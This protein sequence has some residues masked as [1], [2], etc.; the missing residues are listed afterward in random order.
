MTERVFVNHE[1]RE[2]IAGALIKAAEL[3]TSHEGESFDRIILA[4]GIQPIAEAAGLDRVVFLRR[5]EMDGDERVGQIYCWDKLEGALT[6]PEQEPHLLPETQP[7]AHWIGV[8]EKNNCV[9]LRDEDSTTE[10]ER[11]F[12]R[13]FGVK[14][15]MLIPIFS[16]GEFWGAVGFSGR[17]SGLDFDEDCMDLLHSAAHLC[18][19]TVMRAETEEHTQ[20]QSRQLNIRLEQQ[21]LV[22]EIT[23]ILI[24][25]GDTELH[26]EKV[27]AKLGQYYKASQVFIFSID[28][29]QDGTYPTYYWSE[30]NT[31]LRHANVN[32][33][34]WI[35][36]SFPETLPVTFTLP[37]ISCAD[38]AA[39]RH[40]PLYPL[41]EI[42]VNAFMC[43]PLYLEGRLW[44]IMSVEQCNA[45]RHWTENEKLFV[46]MAASTISGII[47][48]NTYT[49][50][51][52]AAL[53]KATE[54][55]RAKSDFL[56]NMSHEMRTPLN[57]IIGM[58]TIGRKAPDIERKNYSL[59]MIEDASAQLLGV[60][61]DVLDM[62]KIAENKLELSYIEFNLEKLLKKTTAI[63]SIRMEE[64]KLSFSMHIDKDIPQ[65]MIGD[66]QRLTQVITNLLGNAVKFTPVNGSIRLET[67]FAGEKGGF[68]TIL[69]SVSDTGIGISEE[70]QKHL[71]ESFQQA[72]SST[73]RRYGGTGLGLAISKSIVEMMKGEI[74]LDS[75]LGKGSVFTFTVRMKRGTAKKQKDL[76]AET[77]QRTEES[78]RGI[79]DLFDGCC[80]LL[81][82]DVE[83]NRDIVLTLLEPTRLKIDCAENGKEVV[84]MFVEASEKYDLIFMDVQMP[85]MD[86]FEATQR[87]RA[88][89][90][91]KAKNI[92][93]IAMTANV[94]REDIEKCL[95]AGMNDHVGKPLN[96]SD[97]ISKLHSYLPKHPQT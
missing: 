45:P 2:V 68:C 25:S 16:R 29:K 38:I 49:A 20:E 22:S 27:M 35:H 30:N 51:L 91:E 53:N 6:F 39:S 74:R 26:I 23:K 86:G 66:D 44:G 1:R 82:E 61:N 46:V 32:I 48:R 33:I 56:S 54:A 97:V 19:N 65:S 34:E 73:S 83:I 79:N 92:P 96:I 5:L 36:D 58:T 89:D 80:I 93:I 55:S 62:S 57:A 13:I 37:F 69:F 75:E 60:I 77:P 84:R 11:D 40:E 72:E 28:R 85:E 14:S 94:F 52:K 67:H 10:D 21:Q 7:A 41:L 63:F 87:I 47:M 31:P 95:G 76:P 90:T 8:L 18:A 88:L 3:F 12:L 43:V 9:N 15:I 50:K 70:Q 81:A 4:N 24:S 64:K 71:F 42:S 17:S 78:N 59:N